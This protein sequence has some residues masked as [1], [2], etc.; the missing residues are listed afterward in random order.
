ME[1]GP[2]KP[3]RY[4]HY[5]PVSQ[6]PP[7]PLSGTCSVRVELPSSLYEVADTDGSA[8][9]GGAD[10]WWF[11]VGAAR[12]FAR[13]Y[14]DVELPNPFGF[15]DRGRWFWWDGAVTGESRLD[16]PDGERYVKE[17]FERLFPGMPVMLI[18]L[19]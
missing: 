3:G 4:G 19:R 8:T 7:S 9:F 14:T 15:K 5:R 2:D 1:I 16:E 13:D 10:D 11:A 12:T 17:F 6:P 18:D